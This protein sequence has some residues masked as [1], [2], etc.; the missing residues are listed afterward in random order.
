MPV[1]DLSPLFDTF[2]Y[3]FFEDDITFENSNEVFDYW[4]MD[5]TYDETE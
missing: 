5:P 3:D 4:H 2:G 1:D